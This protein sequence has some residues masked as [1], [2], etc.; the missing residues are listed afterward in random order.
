MSGHPGETEE[1]V[2]KIVALLPDLVHL[3][4]PSLHRFRLRPM[5]PIHEELDHFGIDQIGPMA[6]HRAAFAKL[7]ESD[8]LGIVDEY[9]FTPRQTNS[10]WTR[11]L[12]DQVAHWQSQWPASG[13]SLW[14]ETGP[15]F[16]HIHDSRPNRQPTR[17]TL[18]GPA[19][20]I[21]AEC[22]SGKSARRITNAVFRNK[23]AESYS[24]TLNTLDSL[25]ER[26]FVYQDGDRYLSLSMARSRHH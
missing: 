14:H 6:W 5:S 2:A 9:D 19:A 22:S 4:P 7:D 15:G 20:E 18:E 26:G 13:G 21:F 3:P 11:R 10:E 8:L 1:D 17:I 25:L 12:A 24:R 23:N 16:V